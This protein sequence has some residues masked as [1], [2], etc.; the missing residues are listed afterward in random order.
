M[1]DEV[2]AVSSAERDQ[3]YRLVVRPLVDREGLKPL[4]SSYALLLGLDSDDQAWMTYPYLDRFNHRMG[5]LAL[6]TYGIH[7][8]E[9]VVEV[10]RRR[11]GGRSVAESLYVKQIPWEDVTHWELTPWLSRGRYGHPELV[12]GTATENLRFGLAIALTYGTSYADSMHGLFSCDDPVP[13]GNPWLADP[14]TDGVYLSAPSASGCLG[15]LRFFSD[16]QLSVQKVSARSLPRL[17]DRFAGAPREPFGEDDGRFRIV[18]NRSSLQCTS[19]STV[20]KQATGEEVSEDPV[21]RRLYESFTFVPDSAVLSPVIQE[22]MLIR[23]PSVMPLLE[24][25]QLVLTNPHGL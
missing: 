13:F 21:R 2:Q 6:D 9:M 22:S 18:R 5:Y 7:Y 12:V 23:A 17:Q 1:T 4:Q 20:L 25:G 19:E 10:T 8:G 24:S 15:A 14:R 3:W 11:F 16:G